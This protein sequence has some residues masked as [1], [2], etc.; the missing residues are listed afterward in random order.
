MFDAEKIIK[1]GKK[2]AITENEKSMILN[3]YGDLIEGYYN[4]PLN[5][6][7]TDRIKNAKE[8]VTKV[9]GGADIIGVRHR[10]KLMSGVDTIQDIML[11]ES[12]QANQ[13]ARIKEWTKINIENGFFTEAEISEVIKLWIEEYDLREED[14]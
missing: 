11:E 14:E 12:T 6:T 4:H 7:V 13:T 2:I 1:D 3:Y 10:Q 5:T 8:L 9:K